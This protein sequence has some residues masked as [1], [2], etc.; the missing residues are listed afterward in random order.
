VYQ[1]AARL[2]RTY[3]RL[4]LADAVGVATALELSGQFVSSDHHELE[5]IAR[6]ERVEFFWFR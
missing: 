3:R 4:S 1:E 5:T 2:K 6:Q